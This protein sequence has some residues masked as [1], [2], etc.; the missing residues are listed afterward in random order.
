MKQRTADNDS[1][2]LALEEALEE[3]ENLT[4]AVDLFFAG[5]FAAI[6][7][8]EEGIEDSKDGLIH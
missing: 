8:Q 7:A 3:V 1:L 5:H 6:H 2:V 4:R